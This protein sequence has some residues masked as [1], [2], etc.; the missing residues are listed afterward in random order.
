[1]GIHGNE[2]ADKL[3]STSATL[4]NITVI[5]PP[6]KELSRSA[7]TLYRTVWD[8]KWSAMSPAT[9]SFKPQLGPTAYTDLPR[10]QKVPLTRMRLGVWHYFKGEH[11]AVCVTCS[12]RLTLTHLLVECPALNHHRQEIRQACAAN[13][14]TLTLST[15]L[16]PDF[17]AQL[18]I[19]LLIAVDGLRRL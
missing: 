14:R 7:R 4:T 18:V 6:A 15:L 13:N 9:N 10:Q 2:K 19:D 1:M 5:N 17:P 12:T 11:P 16:D 3:A 8:T